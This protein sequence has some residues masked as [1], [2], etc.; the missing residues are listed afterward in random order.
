MKCLL[1]AALVL[2]FEAAAYGQPRLVVPM[3]QFDFGFVP[4]N[5]KLTHRFWFRS[6]GTDTLRISEIKTGCACAVMPLT[7]DW[8]APGDSLEVRIDWEIGKN[9]GGVDRFPRVFTNAGPDP[10]QLH[11]KGMITAFPDSARPVTVQPFRFL[12]AK[13]ARKTIDSLSF[14]VTNHDSQPLKVSLISPAAEQ[15]ELVFPDSIDAQ[16]SR[17]GYVKVKRAWADTEFET[18]LT[19]LISDPANTHITLPVKRQFYALEQNR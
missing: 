14:T 8:I 4:Q 7:Q 3:S 13:S 6:L 16:S 1:S 10:V 11:L 2:L 19:L 9:I 15:I 17:T 12:L 18:S 5:S